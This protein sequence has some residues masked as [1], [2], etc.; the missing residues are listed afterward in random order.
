M[1][2]LRSNQHPIKIRAGLR[3]S[4]MLL[5][6]AS[7]LAASTEALACAACGSTL[8]RDWETQGISGNHGFVAELSYDYLNQNRQHYGTGSAS[9]ALIN[10][11]LNAGQEIEAYTKTRTVTATLIYNDDTWGIG[12][13]IPYVQRTHGTYGNA[14]PLGSGYSTSSDSGIGDIRVT[15]RYTGFSEGGTAGVIVGLKLPTGSTN[16]NFNAGAAAGT[17]LDAS[18]QIG[19]GSTDAIFGGYTTG[20]IDHYGWFLQGTVQRAMAT[21]NNFRPGDTYALNVGIRYAGF[22]AR[23]SPMLQLNII[24]RQFDNGTN[25]TPPDPVTGGPTTGGTL[26]YLAPGASVQL[27]GGAS[28]YGFLQL[29]VYRRVN[30]LQLVPQYTLMVGA[31]V[32]F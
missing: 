3:T 6:A 12:A 23:I 13:Q 5:A 9:P 20:T 11:Q 16:A 18:L 14:A 19:T 17:P 29:P 10:R 26:A 30:S 25:A 15:G 7:S 1:L 22:G 21:R 32:A 28:V 2:Q 24:N 31:R 8:S 27:G 4:L